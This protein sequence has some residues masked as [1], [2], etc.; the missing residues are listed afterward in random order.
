[1]VHSF[2]VL[3]VVLV[4]TWKNEMRCLLSFVS[5]CS[6]SVGVVVRLQQALVDGHHVAGS[7]VA[8]ILCLLEQVFRA[9]FLP[10]GFAFESLW[11]CDSDSNPG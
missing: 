5:L 9:S 6:A 8:E 7:T 10:I 1:M 3:L 2:W 4:G 11:P